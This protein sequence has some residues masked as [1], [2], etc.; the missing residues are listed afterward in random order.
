MYCSK[1]TDEST[2]TYLGPIL[3][4]NSPLLPTYMEINIMKHVTKTQIYI[5]TGILIKWKM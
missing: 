1:S 3:H 4:G 2:Y 5:H